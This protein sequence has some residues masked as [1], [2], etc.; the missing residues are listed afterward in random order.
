[1]LHLAYGTIT[2]WDTNTFIKYGVLTSVRTFSG[3]A[4][5]TI[6]SPRG[7]KG[8][9]K[10]ERNFKPIIKPILNLLLNVHKHYTYISL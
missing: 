8:G 4:I 9:R 1:M 10:E 6:I 3:N 5:S 7:P 2:F